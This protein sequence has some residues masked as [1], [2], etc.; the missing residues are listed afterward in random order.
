MTEAPTEAASEMGISKA[1]IVKWFKF[2]RKTMGRI[3]Q[4]EYTKL[5]GDG[6]EVE[7]DE[8]LVAKRKANRGRLVQQQWLFGC[9]ERGSS[10][11]LLKCVDDRS[12]HTLGRL[13]KEMIE[14]DS[15]VYSD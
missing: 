2:Y 4:R 7:I 11:I 15:V 9:I 3:L 10:R 1:T 6:N 8:T 12:R 13:I 5:G 14:E